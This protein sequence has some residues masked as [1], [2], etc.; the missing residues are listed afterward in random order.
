M[1]SL[2][3]RQEMHGCP[4]LAFLNAHVDA[5][6]TQR[7]NCFCM[8]T[9]SCVSAVVLQGGELNRLIFFDVVN[10]IHVSNGFPWW[11]KAPDTSHELMVF[12]VEIHP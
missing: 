3:S 12:C 5:D 1:G 4:A 6:F 9:D 7:S 2:G 10:S 11:L 8:T